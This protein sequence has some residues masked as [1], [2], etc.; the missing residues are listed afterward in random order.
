MTAA[1]T[2]HPWTPHFCSSSPLFQ[3]LSPLMAGFSHCDQLPDWQFLQHQLA[4][5]HPPIN[6]ASNRPLQFVP[7]TKKSGIYPESY[8]ARIYLKG[9]IQ[10][11]HNWH[12]FF[13]A[14]VWFT[15]PQTKAAINTL[16]YHQGLQRHWGHEPHR[17]ALENA[18]T[19]FDESGAIIL[20]SRA[21]YLRLIQNHDWKTLFWD[22]RDLLAQHL[23]C[24]IFGHGLY[25]KALSPYPGMTAQSLLLPVIPEFFQW[26]LTRQIHHADSYAAQQ[27]TNTAI[28]RSPKD[29]QAF[30]LLGM[31]NWDKNNA[32]EYYD[33]KKYFREKNR[34][35]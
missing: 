34:Q 27:L 35:Q 24:F 10:T 8:E 7:Q 9:E 21:E 13:N 23:Q 1:A 26:D 33:N 17:T 3:P 29:L 14:L 30:P 5:Q 22:Q 11:R 15:F 6:T 19:L 20:C 4:Q 25:E 28:F 32:A 18:L 31:P 2:P 16:H 12:D